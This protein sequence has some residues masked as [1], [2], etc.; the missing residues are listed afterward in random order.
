M[1]TEISRRLKMEVNRES[2][3]Q[4]VTLDTY[5]TTLH[6]SPNIDCV[7]IVTRHVNKK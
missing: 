1:H 7:V 2:G 4:H 3:K 5:L 6:S